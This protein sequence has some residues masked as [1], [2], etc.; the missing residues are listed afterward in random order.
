[1]K[2]GNKDSNRSGILLFMTDQLSAKWLE[3]ALDSDIC[4]NMNR[5]KEEGVSFSNAI[6]SNPVCMPARS[7]IATGL[8][9]RGHGV[10]ENGYRLDAD[11][12]TFMKALQGDGW[13]T[14]AFG[15]VHLQPHFAGLFP[16]YHK[17][18][19]DVTHITE[20]ARGGEWLD[21]VKEN[22]SEYYEDVL[23]TIWPYEIPGF[24]DY[25]ADGLNLRDK[26]K[27]IR[28]DYQWASTK[29][30]ENDPS[31]Y[32]LPFPAEVSQ[33][34]WITARAIDF[35]EKID[36]DQSFFAQVSYVQP[37]GPSSPPERYLELVDEDQIPPP[38]PPE[39]L[40]DPDAPDYFSDKEPKGGNWLHKRRC[41]FADLLHLD[42]Q[43]GEIMEVLER[44]G[45]LEETYII[46]LADH[47]DLLFDHG[48]TGKEERHY[49]PCIRVPLMMKGP[50]L[51]E[52]LERREMVQLEDICPTVLEI[53][54]TDLPST[55][56][57][58]PYLDIQAENI[59]IL[60]GKSLLSLSRGKRVADWR[61]AAYS[62]SY[63]AIWSVD[64]G[65]WARTV[66]TAEARYTF[67]PEGNGEQMFDLR[68]DPDEQNNVVNRAEYAELKKDLRKKL[69]ELIV[70]QDFP[71]TRRELFALGVH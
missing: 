21:W 50:G 16:D 57:M 60:S 36:E 4:Q 59:P 33:T 13:R 25:G 32:T 28:R 27:K 47:G 40:E 52:G 29:F 26:I 15:K 35:L 51:K 37:H 7:T 69:M 31:A 58:G 68:E 65:D 20:D 1:M 63:N 42:R 70:M 24:R 19:F 43:L 23:A 45:R 30:P 12:P 64:P 55:P 10:L 18:G 9:T 22:H 67:Y 71:K 5:L 8:T 2:T 3:I 54:S 14:G 66:R 6:S 48:F 53:A 44:R 62:E 39:W 34:E 38:A 11:L 46:F 49:D 41:Y 56:K 61:D 17:Y